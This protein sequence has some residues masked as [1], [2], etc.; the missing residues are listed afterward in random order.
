MKK[1]INIQVGEQYLFTDKDMYSFGRYLLSKERNDNI[2]GDRSEV[3]H[4]DF[5]NWKHKIK[6]P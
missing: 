3:Y 2:K 4:A 6:N 1:E 5:E